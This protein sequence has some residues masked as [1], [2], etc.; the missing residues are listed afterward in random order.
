MDIASPNLIHFRTDPIGT[1][2]GVEF[3][4]W[5]TIIG[6]R[7]YL[8][9]QDAICKLDVAFNRRPIQIACKGHKLQKICSFN[10]AAA[11]ILKSQLL[12]FQR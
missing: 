6:I 8:V 5:K 11:Q 2:G 12:T 4:L 9:P 10:V 3:T 7:V 1:E